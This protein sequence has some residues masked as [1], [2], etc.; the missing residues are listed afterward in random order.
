MAD[1][2]AALAT[3]TGRAGVGIIRLSGPNA[4]AAAD[5]IFRSKSGIKMSDA[6]D[7]KLLYG[8]IVDEAGA[9]LDYGLC[10]VSHAPNSYT[11]ENTAEL[12]CHG[13]PVVLAAV[14]DE[15]FRAGARPAEPGEFT[16]RAFLNGRLDLTQA[17]AV[18]DLID[19]ETEQ[20]AKNAAGQLGG[21]I[22]QKIHTAYDA[23]VD[24]SAHFFAVIDYPDE[25]LEDFKTEDCLAVLDGVAHALEMLLKTYE[26]GRILKDGVKTALIGR[27]N[28]GK[29]SLLNA[30]AGYE[31]AIVTPHAGTTRDTIEEKL[32]FG[33][34]VLRLVDTAGIRHTQDAIESLGVDRA[35]GAAETAALILAVF[36]G[37]TDLTDDDRRILDIAARAKNAVAVVSKSDLA[38]KLDKTFL[39]ARFQNIVEVSAVTGEGLPELGTVLGRLFTGADGVP[40]G[41][42]LTNARQAGAIARA[43]EDIA[44]AAA[45]LQAGVTPDA[46][47]TDIESAMSALGEVTGKTVREDIVSRIFERFCVGK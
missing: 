10:A 40:G 14:L 31:R 8:A 9:P 35:L 43:R 41:E 7:R 13:A 39:K 15:L 16:Q 1:T 47:L 6:E 11:G 30:L 46:V 19:A 18:I 4:I 17:E 34:V 26:R 45:A 36:D 20:A 37:S 33:G 25:A 42:I 2:I 22:A 12:H 38:Q 29:S 5:R 44:R 24:V 23:L 21:A 27:P 3:G 32:R 28:V